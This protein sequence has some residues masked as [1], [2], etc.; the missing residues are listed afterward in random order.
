MPTRRKRTRGDT[1]LTRTVTLTDAQIKVLPTVNYTLIVPAP[2]VSKI[3][4]FKSASIFAYTKAGVYTNI[5]AD[6]ALYFAYGDDNVI[7][8]ADIGNAF[9]ALDGVSAQDN[10][11]TELLGINTFNVDVICIQNIFPK[12]KLGTLVGVVPEASSNSINNANLDGVTGGFGVINEALK[13]ILYSG[14]SNFTGGNVSN[15]M[16][17]VVDY[18]II[19]L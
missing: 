13:M 17:V 1:L 6:A 11:V 5:A 19:T 15:K 7:A 10:Y 16:K 2:G 18:D 12:N 4:I 3:L 8:S 9:K 14:N